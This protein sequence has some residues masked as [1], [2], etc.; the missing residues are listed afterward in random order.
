MIAIIFAANVR[1]VLTTGKSVLIMD[2][3]G[4]FPYTHAGRFREISQKCSS[5]LEIIA[6]YIIL[7]GDIITRSLCVCAGF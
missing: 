7:C 1:V 6:Y 3:Y 5:F 2:I 4:I